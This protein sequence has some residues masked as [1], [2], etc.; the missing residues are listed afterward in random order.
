MMFILDYQLLL[1]EKAAAGKIAVELNEEETEKMQNCV[2][3]I[4]EAIETLKI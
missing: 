4:K 1:I 2:N 3:I